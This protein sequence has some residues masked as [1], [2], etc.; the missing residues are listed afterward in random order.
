MLIHK[1]NKKKLNYKSQ[2]KQ[3][4]NKV[5]LAI[6]NITM[7]KVQ[8]HLIEYKVLNLKK[9]CI[10]IKL[11]KNIK[12]IKKILIMKNLMIVKINLNKRTQKVKFLNVKAILMIKK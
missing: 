12:M 11:T 10:Q 5:N 9:Y 7:I 8:N 4:I 2:H 6:I 1:I 3:F